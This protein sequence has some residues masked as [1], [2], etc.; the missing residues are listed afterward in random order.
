[1]IHERDPTAALLG[2]ALSLIALPFVLAWATYR[3]IK[4]D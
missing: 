4:G 2:I 1:M 3:A